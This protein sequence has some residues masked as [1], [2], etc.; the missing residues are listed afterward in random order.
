MTCREISLDMA[1]TQGFVEHIHKVDW[2]GWSVVATTK[3]GELERDAALESASKRM[4]ELQT[5]NATKNCTQ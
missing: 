3:E 4:G 2:S 1:R 5:L